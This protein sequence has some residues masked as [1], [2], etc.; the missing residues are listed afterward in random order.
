MVLTTLPCAVLKTK[1][2]AVRQLHRGT[3]SRVSLSGCFPALPVVSSCRV[4]S[5]MSPTASQL[6]CLGGPLSWW[7]LRG[8]GRHRATRTHSIHPGLWML[9]GMAALL[10]SRHA[11]TVKINKSSIWNNILFPCTPCLRDSCCTPRH[12]S[13]VSV[14]RGENQRALEHCKP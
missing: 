6:C 5:A 3:W 13:C 4:P 9:P 12:R 14:K 8:F 1:I 11:S 2:K 7:Q 10:L